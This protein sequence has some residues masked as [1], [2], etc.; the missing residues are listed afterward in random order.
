MVYLNLCIGV[1]IIIYTVTLHELAHAYASTYFGDPTPGR[2]GRLTFNPLVQLDP[3][4]SVLFPI[5]SFVFFHFPLGWAFCPIDPSR[6]RNPLRDHALVSLAGPAVNL[7]VVLVCI[8]ILWIE[9]LTPVDSPNRLIFF[10]VGMWSLL[11]GVFNLLPLPGL[12]GYGVARAFMPISLRK[13][14]DDFR[15]MGW[16][17]LVL[18]MVVGS[19]ILGPV[20]EPLLKTYY[21]LLPYNKSMF[22]E[23][24]GYWLGGW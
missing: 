4:Y 19:R 5:L 14:L 24:Y 8:A 12:D 11:L 15:R 1:A 3:I 9:P 23:L 18:A 7:A 16:L 10:G 20:F 2:H 13:P 6:Y 22:N 21:A 17:P